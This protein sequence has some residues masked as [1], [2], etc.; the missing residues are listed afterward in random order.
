MSWRRAAESDRLLTLTFMSLVYGYVF[1]K[2]LWLRAVLFLDDSRGDC[3]QRGPG[4]FYRRDFQFNP[5]LAGGWFHEAQGMVIF[6]I[7]LAILVAFHQSIVRT[8]NLV[9]RRRA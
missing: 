5:E 8:C 4:G 6:V 1:E 3:R 2:R 9:N 7:A